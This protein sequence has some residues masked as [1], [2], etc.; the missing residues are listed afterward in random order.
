VPT[1]CRHNRFIQNCPI[2]REPEAP[3]AARR[4]PRR[5]SSTATAGRSRGAGG[6]KV[7]RV[8]RAA[9]DGYREGL[10]PGLRSSEDARRLADEI[11]FAAGRLAR[12]EADPPGLY[13][14]A[15]IEPDREEG[16]WLAALIALLGPLEGDDPFA[17]V[18]AARVPWASGEGPALDDVAFGP[19]GG[20]R[21]A[22]AARR[23]IAA[24]RAW[25]QRAG[26]QAPALRGD[27]AWTPERRFDRTYERLG[28]LPG[29][30]RPAR[31][32]L[33]LSLGRLGLADVRPGA[34]HFGSDDD[35]SLAG[36]R[37]FG[38]ADLFL[39]ERR[40]RDL[41]DAAEVP[42]EALDLALANF[43]RDGER[44]TQGVGADA[45]DAEAAER[46]ATALGV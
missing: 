5:S 35:A 13:A 1:F 15:A 14:D 28:S 43:G 39:L 33:L 30:S 41:A 37:V 36:R 21:D 11:G 44:V 20:V 17:G 25:A 42:L 46:A 6:V 2:C 24:Y 7:K 3:A 38:I 26:G 10:V 34:L 45:A 23:A 8:G 9:D 32:D 4:A 40:A 16:L 19:R 18:R 22:A 29:F 27:E 12:L 31:Y